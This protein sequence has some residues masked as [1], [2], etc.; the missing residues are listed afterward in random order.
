MNELYN[1]GKGDMS[2]SLVIH[3]PCGK[4]QQ[5]RTDSLAATGKRLGADDFKSP[6]MGPQPRGPD[7][8]VVTGVEHVACLHIAFAVHRQ[9]VEGRQDLSGVIRQRLQLR[10]LRP[11]ARAG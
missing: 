6:G 8:A 9:V 4:K 1:A 3:E 7:P 2:F 10:L 5:C 11:Q